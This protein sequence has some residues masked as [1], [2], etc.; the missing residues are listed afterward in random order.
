MPQGELESAKKSVEELGIGFIDLKAVDLV[1]RLRHVT[2]P[3]R[4][5]TRELLEKGVGF[6][7]S[8]Y[9]YRAVEQSDM[10]LVPDLATARVEDFWGE[11][12]LSLL[13]DI[14]QVKG[15]K[16]EAF[17]L[18]PRQTAR[19]AEEYLRGSGVADRCYLSPE[20][21]FYIFDHVDYAYDRNRACFH[22][23]SGEA[24]WGNS[25]GGFYLGPKD[26]YHAPPPAD[27]LMG[28][29]GAI[30]SYL[31]REGIPV[32]YHHHEIGGAGEV[33]IEIGF[34]ELL[35]AADDTLFIKYAV[36]NIAWRH[37]KSAT[38]MPKPL[39]G[40]PGNG[41]HLHQYLVKGGK[42]IFYDPNGYGGMSELGLYYIGGLLAHGPSLMAFTN[43]STNSYRRL[44]PGFEAPVAFTFGLANRSA[45]IRIPSYITDPAEQRIELRTPDATCNPYL[46]FSAVLM[47]G[48]DGIEQGIDPRRSGFG[49]CEENLYRLSQKERAKIRFAPS[50]LS[51]ALEALEQDHDYLLRGGVFTVDQLD[52]WLRAKQEEVA[53]FYDK[54]HPYEYVLYY[55]L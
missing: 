26:G 14:Q 50:S 2:I 55:D 31:E 46:A 45:A 52:A 37:G 19:R 16:R 17:P 7:A 12:V 44:T 15:G 38:F 22:V 32:R 5:L 6:D 25:R 3:A 54:P 49:P 13:C 42:N 34:E 30:V 33:E 27:R 4:R 23:E 35:R 53:E 24:P 8:N 47:A 36:R 40:Y 10:L 48:L 21:E 1:G 18:D 11:K 9:G 20:L 28:L 39:P 41:M 29:R 51:G 43:P